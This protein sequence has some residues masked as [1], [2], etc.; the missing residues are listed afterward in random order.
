MLTVDF[1]A[2]R[3]GKLPSEIMAT[4]TTF[5]MTVG[6]TAV[7][8]ENYCYEREKRKAEGVAEPAGNLTQEQM[9]EMIKKVKEQTNDSKHKG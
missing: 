4:A 5:D 8:Y 6:Q 7:E 3:Y 9:L 2:K 1:M